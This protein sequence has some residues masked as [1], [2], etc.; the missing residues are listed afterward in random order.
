[1]PA[2]PLSASSAR[3]TYGHNASEPVDV[4]VVGAGIAGITAAIEA[5]RAGARVAIAS[6]GACCSGS[7]FYP[8]T[9]G[10]GLIAP[11]NEADTPDLVSTICTVGCDVAD[12]ELVA[13]FVA[14][15]APAIAWLED[16]EVSL[17]RPAGAESAQETAFIPCFD[18]KHRAWY[19][20]VRESME[21]AFACELK[22][23]GV[24]VWERTELVELVQN[25]DGAIVGATLFNHQNTHLFSLRCGAVVLAT[26][27]TSGL[28]ERRLTSGDVVSSVQ[29]IAAHHGCSLVNIEFM[30]M[31]PGLVAPCRGL[32]FNEKSFRYAQTQPPLS[33][34]LLCLRSTYGPFT[35]RLTSRAVDFAIDAAG[36]EG[37]PLTYQFPTQDVPEFVRTFSTWL[38]EEHGISPTD[39]LRIALYAHASNGGIRIDGTG[40]TGVPGLYACGEA[41]GGM[42][43]ADR[44]G[45]LSSAN[46]LVFGRS[47]GSAAARHACEHPA[48]TATHDAPRDVAS[49]TSRGIDQAEAVSILAT[50]RHTMSTYAMVNRTADGLSRAHD[51]IETLANQLE[52]HAITDA[53][54]SACAARLRLTGELTLARLMVGAMYERRESRGSHHRSDYPSEDPEQA[55]MMPKGVR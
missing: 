9:W 18:H 22:R 4:L 8:G 2:A 21:A 16:M 55:R 20:L 27:G 26:G 7:S 39:E 33:Y 37:L 41:T 17:K 23:L 1:M 38:E 3:D 44:I 13:S 43:G 24:R 49:R 54:A 6:L 25:G 52:R 28:F 36:P 31:M 40:W 19:G 50:L 5:A 45:G 14:G 47:A 32:V 53:P 51:T 48:C 29:G 11:A 46:G 10:L 30:Q 12:R 34:D 35:S 42:H 15:I